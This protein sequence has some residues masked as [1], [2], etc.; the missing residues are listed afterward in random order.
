MFNAPDW[1]AGVAAERKPKEL[2]KRTEQIN[3]KQAEIYEMT[4]P[5]KHRFEVTKS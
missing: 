5:I 4:Q 2:A 3:G 1:L